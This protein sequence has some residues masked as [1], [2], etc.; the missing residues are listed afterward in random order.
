MKAAIAGFERLFAEI[1][2]RVAIQAQV[3][4]D[5]SGRMLL[6]TDIA[7]A[8][9]TLEA[10]AD[11]RDRA[12]L[13]DWARAHARAD[14]LSGGERVASGVVHSER[15]SSAQHRHRRRGL[16][17]RAGADGADAR[18]VR[19][20]VR[21]SRGRRLLRNEARA[22]RRRLCDRVAKPAPGRQDAGGQAS[23]RRPAASAA[24]AFRARRPRCARR[25]SS[26]IRSRCSSASA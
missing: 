22:S 16:S 9:T 18:R 23:S 10:L 20:A 12:Q 26:R 15:R 5:T 14:P 3:T 21:R 25:T 1:G 8:M 7:S 6:G 4:L 24:R 2:R 13:L 11:R 19:R 17:A